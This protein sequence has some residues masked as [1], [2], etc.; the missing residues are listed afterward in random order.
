MESPYSEIIGLGINYE[1][2]N[3]RLVEDL[4]DAGRY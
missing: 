3:L 4:L 2:T 1:L